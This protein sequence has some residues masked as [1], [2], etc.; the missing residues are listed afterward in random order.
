MARNTCENSPEPI[1][2][3]SQN[4]ECQ[5]MLGLTCMVGDDSKGKFVGVLG[6]LDLEF[7]DA[8]EEKKSFA[9]VF[10]C[11]C[12]RAPTCIERKLGSGNTP[13][14]FGVCGGSRRR[15]RVARPVPML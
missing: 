6:I 9:G 8:T 13:W 15:G 10:G 11:C 5:L 4:R 7:E 12:F 14:S 2:F 3:T 1:N